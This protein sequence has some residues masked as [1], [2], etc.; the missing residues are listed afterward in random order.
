MRRGE[1]FSLE[2]S[3]VNFNEA[4]VRV[5][6]SKSGH[7]R[8]VQMNKSVGDL[9]KKWRAQTSG[10]GLVFP[11]KN[12]NRLDNIT[13]AWRA[14]MK[15]AQIEGFRFHDLRHDFASRLVSNGV[16]LNTVRELLGH[17]DMKMTLRYAHLAPDA[18]RAAV[19][20]LDQIA[21]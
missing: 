13:S 16:S 5:A 1:I 7:S 21:K 9:L 3:D 10:K 8:T 11:G 14:L 12:G 4:R 15:R 2:W 20:I 19:A 18:G 6:D 17:S